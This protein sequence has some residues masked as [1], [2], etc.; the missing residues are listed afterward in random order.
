MFNRDWIKHVAIGLVAVAL[1]LIWA[2]FY[3]GSEI[4]KARGESNKH[5]AEY[6]R[7]AEEQIR[8]TC[9]SGKKGDIAECVSKIIEATNED[10]RAEDDLIAQTEMA[11][12]ALY[13]LIATLVVAVIT[14]VGVYYVWQTLKVTRDIGEAQVRAYISIKASPLFKDL[15]PDAPMNFELEVSNLGSSPA[16]DLSYGTLLVVGSADI[17]KQIFSTPIDQDSPH[18]QNTTI[19]ANQSIKSIGELILSADQVK[20]VHQGG[21]IIYCGARASYS[22]VFGWCHEVDFLVSMR[23]AQFEIQDDG[24]LKQMWGLAGVSGYN[25]TKLKTKKK[26]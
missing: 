8:A 22:D 7:H 13:M 25:V 21:S 12:W 19:S 16:F 5:T 20:E 1:T 4:G 11:R 18:R 3:V 24:S 9:L 10:S 2:A 17:P 26:N 6:E 15:A 23:A 14:G